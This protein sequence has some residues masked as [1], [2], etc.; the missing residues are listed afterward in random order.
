MRLGK[1]KRLPGTATEA[2]AVAAKLR[3]YAG[4]TP[5][6]H[7]DKEAST[8]LFLAARS[9][10]IVVLST[11]GYFLP[12]QEEKPKDAEKGRRR[13]WENP[14]LRCGL[15]L[16]GCNNPPKDGDSG[17][18]VFWWAPYAGAGQLHRAVPYS[19]DGQ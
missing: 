6:V 18:R 2:E 16:A 10:R 3:K 17:V 15:L 19:V 1:I 5:R 12:D 7:T 9:P 8:G 11:H 13:R 14:L 4:A